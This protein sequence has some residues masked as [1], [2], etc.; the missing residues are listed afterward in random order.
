MSQGLRSKQPSASRAV[1]LWTVVQRLPTHR[2]TVWC[3]AV[4]FNWF[5]TSVAI[6]PK[7]RLERGLWEISEETEGRWV[8]DAAC[9]EGKWRREMC[10]GNDYQ[11]DEWKEHMRKREAKI[12]KNLP[13]RE[14]RESFTPPQQERCVL[15]FWQ[16]K[17]RPALIMPLSSIKMELCITHLIFCGAMQERGP[18]YSTEKNKGC[19]WK[20]PTGANCN[21]SGPSQ[22]K[23]RRNNTTTN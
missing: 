13:R 6:C 14:Q 12:K 16:S 22:G 11:K 3:H 20:L 5:F 19:G 17:M 2:L 18:L 8:R 7:G 9:R 21:I 15:W 4:K 1:T 10:Q 23:K